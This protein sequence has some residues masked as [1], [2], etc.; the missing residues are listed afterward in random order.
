MTDRR[1]NETRIEQALR[2]GA[3]PESGDG[4]AS[5]GAQQ[6]SS[7]CAADAARRLSRRITAEG[8]ADVSYAPVDSPFGTL[9][10]AITRRGLVR[11]AFPEEDVDS[12][13]EASRAT[14]LAADRRG[15]RGRWTRCGASWRS[16]S[17]DAGAA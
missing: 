5:A 16:T 11:L 13:L 8:L 6:L 10:L 12:V 9:L 4:G 14:D 17:A 7:T 3:G 2:R 15:V 1:L